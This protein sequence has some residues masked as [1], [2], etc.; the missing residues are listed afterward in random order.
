MRIVLLA[1]AA[2]FQVV[3]PPVA[4]DAAAVN[5]LAAAVAGAGAAFLIGV[6][7]KAESWLSVA[8]VS[9]LGNLTPAL[10]AILV[11]VVAQL[12]PM[13]HIGALTFNPANGP[14]ELVAVAVGILTREGYQKLFGS[15]LPGA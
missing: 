11:P 10:L 7:K 12:G 6:I 9:K 5:V 8:V 4:P 14:G 15:P 1:L 2:I 13:L 3:Q